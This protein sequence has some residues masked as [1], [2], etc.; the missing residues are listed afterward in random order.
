MGSYLQKN[1]AR[2]LGAA[3]F[4]SLIFILVIILDFFFHDIWM[5]LNT[6]A[7]SVLIISALLLVLLLVY[8]REMKGAE[9]WMM[10]ALGEHK[11]EKVL[12]QLPP[13]Y[14]VFPDVILGHHG[15]IDF[16][17]VGPTGVWT[18]E[19]KSHEGWVR[20]NGTILVH[21]KNKPFEKDF[22]KQAWSQTISVRGVLNNQL[23][24]IAVR[25]VVVF[26]DAVVRFHQT[27]RGIYVVERDKL[28]PLIT[29]FSKSMTEQQVQET[30][31][32]L[33]QY[34]PDRKPNHPVERR[35]GGWSRRWWT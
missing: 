7:S 8:T 26:S 31:D 16:V 2:H 13:G 5:S 11:I 30:V 35:G 17:V 18:V 33:S 3:A 9:P 24:G 21:G 29:K 15:N 25:P 23:S 1:I 6:S 22:L 12:D 32:L 28:L 19:V 14:V 34:L 27:A 20:F 4:I 10:G